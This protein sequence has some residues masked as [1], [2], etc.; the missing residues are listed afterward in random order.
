MNDVEL[1][2]ANRF[3]GLAEGYDRHR[4]DYPS[5]LLAHIAAAPP[6]GVPTLAVDVGAGTGIATRLIAGHLPETWRMAGIEPNA[7]MRAQAEAR[8]AADSRIAYLDAEAEALP[9]DDSTAGLLTVAQAIHWFDKPRFYPEVARV[10][11]QGGAFAILYNDRELDAGLPGAFEDLMEAEMPG[12]DRRY[13]QTRGGE[14][15]QDAELEALD[16]TA[17]VVRHRVRND[18]I[19][20]PEGF[21]GLMLSRSKLKPFA[22]KYGM[23]DATRQ[24]VDLAGRFAGA[25]GNVRLGMTSRVHIA[26]KG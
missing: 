13:R 14:A 16:W 18:R 7:D 10:L 20:S 21:A 19:M 25:D 24:L 26:I 4:P 2:T 22:A 12:Y 17:S 15:D 5:E 23:D 3:S 8:E 1:T 11:A 9:F 6:P